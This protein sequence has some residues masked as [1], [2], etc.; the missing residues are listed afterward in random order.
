M[1]IQPYPISE[2]YRLI[3]PGPVVMVSTSHK[4][5]DNVMTMAWHTMM[6]FVPPLIGCIISNRDFTFSLIKASRECVIAVP[7]V[8]LAAAAVKV[9]NVTGER[10]DK[11]EKFKLTKLPA[12]RVKAPLIAECYAN[13]ECKVVDASWAGKY[14]FFVLQVVKAWVDKDRKHPRMIHHSG[15]G[16]FTVD[17][18][19]IRF[20]W[21]L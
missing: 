11:F 7:T 6:E 18:R 3:E 5:K 21:K 15:T 16:H 12:G 4:G 14:N 10:M 9:G 8:E 17:G 1:N 2:A 20:P 19:N 13:L